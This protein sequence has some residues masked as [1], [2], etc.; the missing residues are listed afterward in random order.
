MMCVSSCPLG[1]ALIVVGAGVSVGAAGNA[2]VASWAGLLRNG[3]EAVEQVAQRG[4]PARCDGAIWSCPVTVALVGFG[5]RE[6]AASEVEGG[7][8]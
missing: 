8:L 2:P 4:L 7:S 1:N 3:V 5:D 6:W